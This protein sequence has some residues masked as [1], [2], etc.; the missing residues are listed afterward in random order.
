V[1]ILPIEVRFWAKVKKTDGCWQW[2]GAATP[3]GYGFLARAIN[4]ERHPLRAHRFSWEL[5]R[6]PVPEGLWV[7]HRCDNPRCV[8][9]DHLFLGDRT[10]NMRDCAAKGRIRGG[11]PRKTVC[12]RGHEYTPDNLRWSKGRRSCRA[13]E[14]I[15]ADRRNR[16]R[17]EERAL[18]LAPQQ[19]GAA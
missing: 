1:R 11:G 14:R 7:L 19:A 12:I 8:N 5:H 9:P 4:G 15:T 10:A 6:G 18:R 13:C 2:T 3:D 17:R 16:L